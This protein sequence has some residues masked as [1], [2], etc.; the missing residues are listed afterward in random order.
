MSV[1]SDKVVANLEVEA[2]DLPVL[3]DTG[4][5]H[6]HIAPEPSDAVNA[7]PFKMLRKATVS[8]PATSREE[9]DALTEAP[10]IS[11]IEFLDH[12]DKPLETVFPLVYKIIGQTRL[13]LES[14]GNIPYTETSFSVFQI[15]FCQKIDLL[16]KIASDLDNNA[17]IHLKK[18]FSGELFDLFSLST[19]ISRAIAKPFGYPGDYRMLDLLYNGD[20]PSQTNLGKYLDKYFIEDPLAQ[21]VINRCNKMANITKDYILKNEST[22]TS[23]HILNIASGPGYDLAQLANMSPKCKTYI[24]CFDQEP[25]SLLQVLS[26][27]G[28]DQFGN[29]KFSFYKEDIRS[30]FRNPCH[31]T[32]YDFI[33][34]IG[35]ADYLSDRLLKSLIEESLSVLNSGGKL[36][37][38]HKDFSLFPYHYPSWLCNWNFIHRSLSQYLDFVNANFPEYDPEITFESDNKVIYFSTLTKP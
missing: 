3:E 5:H 36:V 21:A 30:F 9:Q 6:T 2:V 17:A 34:N 10:D 7:L 28:N 14:F 33:Y 35:L 31:E 27:L 32:S 25:S 4:I 8:F 20:L 26:R 11:K 23:L 24:H 12:R 18:I 1:S 38:A 22:K 37:L 19:L 13:F 16:E 15:Q 29:L